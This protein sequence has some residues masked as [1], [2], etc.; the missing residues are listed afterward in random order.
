M[1][2]TIGYLGPKGTYTEEAAQLYVK[3]YGG[4]L[5]PYPSIREIMDAVNNKEIIEGV[6]PIENAIEGSVGTTLDI[7]AEK[8]TK[9]MIKQEIDI[10]IKHNLLAPSGTKL[11]TITDVISH[12]QAIAQCQKYLHK[13]LPKAK[14]HAAN[15]TAEAAAT[16][17]GSRWTTS[18]TV[19]F[20]AIASEMAAKNYHLEIIA[21]NISD[22]PDNITRFIVVSKK[23][24]ALTHQDKTSLIFDLKK[25]EAGALF[26]ILEVFAKDKINLTK[27]E[28]RPS[29]TKIGNYIF[30]VD[31]EGHRTEKLI[32]KVL[33]NVKKKS[34]FFKLLGSYPKRVDHD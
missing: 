11:D 31:L 25:N 3:Q 13:H 6:V 10:H 29:K 32:K 1:T 8:N 24:H 4:T 28:S 16:I 2:K 21:K 26:K 9:L 17:S 30:F 20:A 22:Y 15:S 27:I 33:D 34:S 14:H 5:K 7:L 18:D 12:P 19:H 23:D